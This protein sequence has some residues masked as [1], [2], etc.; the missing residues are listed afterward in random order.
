[1]QR[2][3]WP[4]IS[5]ISPLVQALV[6]F[7]WFSARRTT[8]EKETNRSTEQQ[9][10]NDIAQFAALYGY[11]NCLITSLGLLLLLES[12]DYH[13]SFRPRPS[14]LLLCTTSRRPLTLLLGSVPVREC[15]QV[16]VPCAQLRAPG[17]RPTLR[18]VSF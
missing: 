9:P 2:K 10:P 6:S 1:M 11:L 8:I 4:T 17:G 18:F 12:R 13:P 5:K 16:C 3:L 7:C 15:A 14:I